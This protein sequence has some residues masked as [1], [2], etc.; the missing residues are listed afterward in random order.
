MKMISKVLLILVIAIGANT[1]GASAQR[2]RPNKTSSA[3]AYY[4][5]AP[6][7]PHFKQKKTTKVK[8]ARS[9]SSKR[10]RAD[11]RNRKK[12]S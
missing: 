8:T 1:I 3:K 12:Y 10:V 9:Q 7:K 2:K 11:V 5:Q 4:G 6:S